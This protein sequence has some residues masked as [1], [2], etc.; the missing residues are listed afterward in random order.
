MIRRIVLAAIAVG[1]LGS[2]AETAAIQTDG[3]FLLDR[4]VASETDRAGA[5]RH[6]EQ[7]IQRCLVD[8]GFEYTVAPYVDV[9][10]FDSVAD[11]V[12]VSES[13]A[14]ERGY[15][16]AATR[17][18]IEQLQ[19]ADEANNL[20]L[21]GLSAKD[22]D[23]YSAVMGNPDGDGCYG[24]AVR[25]AQ[26]AFPKVLLSTSENELVE[27]Q[28]TVYTRKLLSLGA[29]LFAD[30]S[31]CMRGFGFEFGTPFDARQSVAGRGDDPE[32]A[33]QSAALDEFAVS[34]ADAACQRRD[35]AAFQKLSD[36]ALAAAKAELQ[37][38]G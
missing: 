20:Y 14:A 31:Q 25:E 9:T 6:R 4:P 22:Q 19:Q 29:D 11:L 8:E 13:Q 2:C 27:S 12:L 30:W 35:A 34:Q 28:T 15:G 5:H 1:S 24:R 3:G 21:G 16:L 38:S 18:V 32:S 10:I 17:G 26:R 36:S 33:S 37:T 7:S 23:A